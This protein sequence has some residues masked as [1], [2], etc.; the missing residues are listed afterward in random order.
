MYEAEGLM[1]THHVEAPF[2][3]EDYEKDRITLDRVLNQ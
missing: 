3:L 1:K 2:S